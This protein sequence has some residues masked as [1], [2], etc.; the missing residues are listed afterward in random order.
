MRFYEKL[1]PGLF[2]VL[3]SQNREIYLEALYLIYDASLYY[4]N[5]IP[6][7]HLKKILVEE[8][9][10]K[11]QDYMPESDE[12][13]GDE[14][15]TAE[16]PRKVY[17]ILRNLVSHGWLREGFVEDN[18][19][20]TGYMIEKHTL[21]LLRILM[22]EEDE[23]NISYKGFVYSTFS[24]LLAAE[25][26]PE[27]EYKGLIDP[28]NRYDALMEARK[29]TE[30]FVHSLDV[31]WEGIAGYMSRI[32][33]LDDKKLLEEHF[34]G[35]LEK[36]N[37]GAIS[38]MMTNDSVLRF[39]NAI[40]AIIGKWEVDEKI[41]CSLV[42][43]YVK[44]NP[45]TDKQEAMHEINKILTEIDETYLGI[46]P[47]INEIFR[48]HVKYS[49]AVLERIKKM[50]IQGQ[51]VQGLILRIMKDAG[52]NRTLREEMAG[53]IDLSSV[54][55][56]WPSSLLIRRPAAHVD[57]SGIQ[58]IIDEE[59]SKEDL[60]EIIEEIK[61]KYPEGRIDSF[62]LSRMG[63]REEFST[64]EMVNAPMSLEDIVCLIYALL[65][66]EEGDRPFFCEWLDK[67]VHGKNGWSLPLA[68]F[69]KKQPNEEVAEKTKE[70]GEK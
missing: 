33:H 66:V 27:G 21:V 14:S 49:A 18:S 58:P 10:P 11:L 59:I 36:I 2:N 12:Y 69:R 54:R 46:M 7:D 45:G 55:C 8:L 6:A 47:R 37:A 4:S 53:S 5:R 52:G 56:L 17:S 30:D 51:S 16:A 20:K 22:S 48:L 23:T 24:V 70:L 13:D 28:E 40:R 61:P 3:T 62:V 67:E 25:Q 9:S 32:G 15:I 60:N 68:V 34:N 44:R 39:G 43:S 41:L 31:L 64:E 42:D 57:Y 19:I 50:Y 26:S 29:H 1:P 38:P 35:Y 65:V 63:N